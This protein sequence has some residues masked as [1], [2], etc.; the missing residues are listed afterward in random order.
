MRNERERLSND[1][2]DL[3]EIVR[4]A[5]RQKLWLFIVAIPILAIGLAYAILS[6]PV[7]EARFYVQ[8][9]RQSDISQLNY[10]RGSSTGLEYLTVRGVYDDYLGALQSQTV[11]NK[12]F[13]TIYLPALTNEERKQSRDVLYSEFGRV[14]KVE[15]AGK[16]RPLSYVITA[17][18]VEPEQAV[19][20]VTAYA[21]LASEAAKLEVIEGSRSEMLSRADNIEQEILGAK[22]AKRKEREDRIAQL[23]EALVVARSIGLERPPLISGTLSTEVSAGMNGA[24]TYM[25]GSKALESEI[26]TLESRASD[27]PFI[28]GLREKEELSRFFRSVRVDP[29]LVAVFQQDGVLD[30][31]DKPIKPR[32]TFIV[33]A[34]LMFGLGLGLAVATGREL[35]LRR[36][37]RSV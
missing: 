5:W 30:S 28:K 23:K 11:R 24:L 13:R 25:R 6:A 34:S 15:A 14:M 2:V 33:L 29:S 1:E 21:N 19:A 7:Y 36:S 27:D 8:P 37:I 3:V 22:A 4:G 31:P 16:G 9:P 32:K 18:T 12:F 17:Q 35:W 26:A 20:W 10:G